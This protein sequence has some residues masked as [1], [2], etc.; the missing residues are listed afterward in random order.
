MR[1]DLNLTIRTARETAEK[2]VRELETK[3]FVDFNQKVTW[4]G[5]KVLRLECFDGPQGQKTLDWRRLGAIATYEYNKIG[6]FIMGTF[7]HYPLLRNYK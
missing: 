4:D 1:T 5:N 6:K 2:L 7:Q 3:N